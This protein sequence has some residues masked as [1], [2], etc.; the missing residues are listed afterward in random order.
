MSNPSFPVDVPNE[1]E[2]VS[3][4]GDQ[5]L[6]RVKGTLSET[7]RGVQRGEDRPTN[8]SGTVIDDLYVWAED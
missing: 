4:K 3:Y 7:H 8:Q 6:D 1:G 5:K 2:S